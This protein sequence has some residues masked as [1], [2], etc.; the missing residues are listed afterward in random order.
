ML[1]TLVPGDLFVIP[2]YGYDSACLFVGMRN[3]PFENGLMRYH[4]LTRTGS[5]EMIGGS[6]VVTLLARV[7]KVKG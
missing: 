3:S 7:D 5:V 6:T 4:F 2:E 1:G